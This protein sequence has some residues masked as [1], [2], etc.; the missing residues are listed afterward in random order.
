[1]AKKILAICA[2]LIALAAV[3]AVASASPELQ[4]SGGT[5]VAVGTAIK[6][7]NNGNTILTSSFG[8]VTCTSSTLEGKVTENSGTSIKGEISTATYTGT[9]PSS[10]CTTTLIGLNGQNLTAQVTVQNLPYELVSTSGVDRADI[11]DPTALKFTFDLF[12]STGTSAGSCTFERTA[13]E[14]G[15][16]SSYETNK[17]PLELTVIENNV[18][19]RVSGTTLCPSTGTLDAKYILRT[20]TG[21]ELKIV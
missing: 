2:A 9:G 7:T 12:E 8:N 21:G 16:V 11:Q 20:S 1:M 14:G 4:T 3:P 19:K 17:S 5:K 15:I 18:F 13:A 6:G 10:R